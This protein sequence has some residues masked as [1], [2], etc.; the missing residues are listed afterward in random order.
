MNYKIFYTG[1]AQNDLEEIYEYIAFSLQEPLIAGRL[2]NA[3]IAAVR[4][5]DTFPLRCSQYEHEPW[6]SRGL[7]KLTVKKYIVF[8]TVD[9]EKKIVTVIRIMYGARDL[10]KHLREN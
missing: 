7:R 4:T 8:Y 3:I 2:L 9:E 1:K 10:E 5:L 6:R